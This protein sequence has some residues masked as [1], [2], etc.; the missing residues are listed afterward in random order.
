[1]QNTREEGTKFKQKVSRLL[2]EKHEYK[3]KAKMNGKN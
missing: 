2:F 3:K 1:M